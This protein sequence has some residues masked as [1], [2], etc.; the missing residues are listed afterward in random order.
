VSDRTTEETDYFLFSLRNVI[1]A[2]RVTRLMTDASRFYP[3][4]DFLSFT[5]LHR[6]WSP[7]N[8]CSSWR[9]IRPWSKAAET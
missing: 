8:S 2:V 3:D 1:G 9:G 6:F 5:A 4:R 7:P